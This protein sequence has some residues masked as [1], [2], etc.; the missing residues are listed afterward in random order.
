[1]AS[2]SPAR[3]ARIVMTEARKSYVNKWQTDPDGG[4]LRQPGLLPLRGV[5][6]RPVSDSNR[7]SSLVSR[8]PA[9]R[10]SPGM[11]EP[12]ARSSGPTAGR[13]F[14]SNFASARQPA[15]EPPL[16]T[17]PKN[18]IHVSPSHRPSR[19]L[20]TTTSAWRTRTARRSCSTT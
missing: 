8:N 6:V 2:A 1:M 5:L 15:R 12:A 10:G 9:P 17:R 16:L 19:D 14:S 11:T 4:A 13:V 7:R 18:A 20:L 3:K